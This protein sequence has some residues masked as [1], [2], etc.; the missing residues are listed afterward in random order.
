MQTW[1][2]CIAILGA[3]QFGFTIAVMAGALLFLIPIYHLDPAQQGHV[4]SAILIG[5]LIGAASGGMLAE[6]YGRKRAQIIIAGFFLIG[7]L[8]VVFSSSI[9]A[10]I[11]GRVIQGLAVGAISVVGP[12]YIAEVS[13]PLTRGR[14][15]SFYQLSVTFGI[16]CAYS[17]NYLFAWDGG[18]RWM[19]AVGI[20]PAILHGLGFLFLPETQP[21]KSNEPSS[22]KTL[23]KPEYRSSLV[24]A[25]SINFFQQLTG[26]NAVIYFAPSIFE[27]CGFKSAT[28]AIFSAVLI[29]AINFV[30]TIISIFLIDRKG[31]KPLLLVGLAGMIIA[32]VAL[33]T[34]CYLPFSAAPWV[35]TGSLMIYIGC[36]A[37][38]LGPIPQ[39]ITSEMFPNT[40]RSRGVSVA[41]FTS[42]ICN[43]LVVFTFMDLVAY[44]SQAGTFLLYAV[45]GLIAF[46]FIWKKIPETK[47]TILK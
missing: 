16:L 23:L 19:F 6:R 9:N 14:N 40:I 27:M 17:V 35:A 47:G 12:M 44:I 29:G 32:L 43:F 33:S 38:G 26:I 46:Y 31:R 10:I 8:T 1:K 11:I 24:S 37:F 13:P 39:L 21:Q 34:A 28:T 4:V 20:I 36:F 30:S 2:Y 15:V 25:I 7:T 18:W 5:A 22:W 45:F 3:F 41:M 42:W